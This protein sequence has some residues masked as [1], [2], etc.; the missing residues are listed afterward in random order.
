MLNSKFKNEILNRALY[1]NKCLVLNDLFLK[2]SKVWLQHNTKLK[3]EKRKI[4]KLKNRRKSY[5]VHLTST[6]LIV[7]NIYMCLDKTNLIWVFCLFFKFICRLL[8]NLNQL[9]FLKLSTDKDKI[10]I[11]LFFL[12]ITFKYKLYFNVCLY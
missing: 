6:C 4:K 9:Y 1:S 7:L 8:N 11:N 3:K 2:L 12:T 5:A 10:W